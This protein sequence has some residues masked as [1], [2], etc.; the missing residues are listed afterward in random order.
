MNRLDSAP[1]NFQCSVGEP[2]ISERAAWPSQPADARSATARLVSLRLAAV[3]LRDA[4]AFVEQWHRHHQPLRGHVFS[5]GAA[6]HGGVLNAV[7]VVDMPVARH[8]DDGTAL[9]EVTRTC[10]DAA[11]NACSLL[12][13]AAWRAAKSL[14][15]TRLV[16]YTQDRETGASLRGANWHVVAERRPRRGWSTPSRPRAPKGADGIARTLWLAPPIRPAQT[17]AGPR[18]HMAVSE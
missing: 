9:S 13:G 11:R 6:D 15:Y 17:G 1:R 3:R 14:G 2:R 4:T 18:R 5:I 12:Y 8:F 10:S 7:D 16:T